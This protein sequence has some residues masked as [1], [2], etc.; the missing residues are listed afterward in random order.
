MCVIQQ[1]MDDWQLPPWKLASQA[2]MCMPSIVLFLWL[3]VSIGLILHSGGD[4]FL[5][6]SVP[7]GAELHEVESRARDLAK[8]MRRGQVEPSAK[9]KLSLY[10]DFALFL[11]DY[12][13]DWAS[14]VLNFKNREFVTRVVQGVIIFIPVM[15][16]CHRGKIQV[17]EAVGG[18]IRSHKKGYPTNAFMKALRSEKSVEAPLSLCL[19]YY[20]VLRLTTPFSFWIALLSMSLSICSLAKFSYQTFE[21][22]VTDEA[23]ADPSIDAEAQVQ[24][25]RA[26]NALEPRQRTFPDRPPGVIP[27]SQGA[28]EAPKLN[29]ER[30]L[31]V[32]VYSKLKLS[33]R[34]P[35]TTS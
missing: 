26:Q 20:S 25:E 24:P 28:M 5:L 29:L 15:L 21:L 30:L 13:T 2:L 10:M 18:F 1:G 17:V 9:D 8:R 3:I 14:M 32:R 33:V 12:V 22:G 35:E 19:Q 27:P 16:D 6:W 7:L 34:K 4:L 31:L 11:L 23:A